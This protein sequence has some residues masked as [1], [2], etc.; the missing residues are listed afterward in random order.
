MDRRTYEGPMDWEYQ[1]QPPVDHSSP[2]AKFSQKQPTCE[3]LSRPPANGKL[4]IL[5]AYLRHSAS[6]VSWAVRFHVFMLPLLPLTMDPSDHISLLQ[7]P[8][9]HPRNSDQPILTHS[10]LRVSSMVRLSNMKRNRDRRTRHSSTLSYSAS[11]RLQHFEI[12]PSR[13]PKNASMSLSCPNTLLRTLAL[14]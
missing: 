5:S 14:A 2:F 10:L 8:S 3:F 11:H 9:V 4:F 1:S 13:L 12:P 6:P 7:Q